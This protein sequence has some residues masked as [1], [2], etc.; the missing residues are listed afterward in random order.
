ME[1]QVKR[2]F[3]THLYEQFARIGK[4]LSSAHRLELLECWP[5][6]STAWKH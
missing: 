1:Q 6:G 3:K 2:D 4:A 5:R